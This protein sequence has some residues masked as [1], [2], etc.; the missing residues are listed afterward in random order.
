MYKDFQNFV[1]SCGV[2]QFSKEVSQNTELYTSIFVLEKPWSDIN[3]DFVLGLPKTTRGYDSIF[4]VVGRFFKMKYFIPACK[5]KSYVVHIA[6]I[7]FKVIVRL[8]EFPK[9]II[10][11][12]DSK[13]VGYFWR[14]LWKK[15]DTEFK[16]S[17]TFYL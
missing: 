10:F 11:D 16:F 1:R 14:T 7:F 17:S 6:K 12:K 2:C 3:M 15:I 8:H 9:S 4:V 5:K 13:F